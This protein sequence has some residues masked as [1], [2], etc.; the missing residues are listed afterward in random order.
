M[1]RHPYR[2]GHRGQADS[3][4]VPGALALPR[5]RSA[6]AAQRA[7]TAP[8]F[9]LSV[10]H[11]SPEALSITPKYLA[12]SRDG[13]IYGATSAV[14]SSDGTIFR[15]SGSTYTRIA[16]LNYAN[17]GGPF[18]APFLGTNGLLYGLTFAGG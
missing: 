15:L 3:A 5:T 14:G 9:T 18:G 17:I 2:G 12:L 8:G 16:V 4:R 13:N 10:V 1:F 6:D 7:A 11:E